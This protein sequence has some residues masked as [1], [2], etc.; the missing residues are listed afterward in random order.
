MSHRF[1][2][3]KKI[4]KQPAARLLASGNAKVKTQTNLPATATVEEMLLALS[5]AKSAIALVDIIRL[6]S[7]ALPARERTWWAC[8]AARQMLDPEIK[9]APASLE[10]A[11]AWVR[12]P[13]DQTREA[14]RQAAELAEVDDDTSLC[15]TS[16]VF[17]DEKLGAGDMAQYA[18]PAGASSAAVFGMITIALSKEEDF[19][20]GA[21]LMIDRA[22]DIARGGNGQIKPIFPKEVVT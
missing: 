5:K 17:C 6:L 14:A 18:A 10:A 22:V 19:T 12:K 21:Q 13:S 7:V 8:V 15:A 9:K 1:S 2:D 4:P 16:V 11:E 3:L 20:S